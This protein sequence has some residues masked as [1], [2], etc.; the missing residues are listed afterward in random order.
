[1]TIPR[2]ITR[3]MGL[4][5]QDTLETYPTFLRGNAKDLDALY[6]DVLITVTSFFRDP[7]AFDVLRRK[8]FPKILQQRGDEPVRAWVLGCSTGQEVYSIAMA[9]TEAAENVTRTRKLQVF[10]TD[11]ND[12][13]LEK[14]RHGLYAKSLAQDVSPERLRRFFVEEEGGYR[15][16]KPLRQMVVFARQN[17]ITDPPF[18]RMALI[19]CRNRLIFLEPSWKKKALPTFHYALK[20][21]GYLFLGA[22]ESIG[23]FT[24]LFEPTD[25]KHKIYSKKAAPTRALHLPVRKTR[26]Q[27]QSPGQ[28]PKV[29]TR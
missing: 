29:R 11:L 13:L 19:S 14:A 7:D 15:I 26:E 3:R 27:E 5:K 24:D 1:T 2:R 23:H 17:L 28:L 10:A 25:K 20:P 21:E 12:A 9:F 6:S 18:S 16:I 4:N 8:V 22:S